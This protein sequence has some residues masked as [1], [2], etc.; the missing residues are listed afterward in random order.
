MGVYSVYARQSL[1]AYDRKPGTLSLGIKSSCEALSR[2]AFESSVNVLYILNN[3]NRMERIFQYFSTYTSE[4]RKQNQKW[5]KSIANLDP[6]D[7][8]PQRRGMAQ[9]TEFLNLAENFLGEIANQENVSYPPQ[10][11]SI[12]TFDKFQD[13]S[14]E[15]DYRTLYAA[16]S[17]QIHNDAEDLL[18]NF[19]LSA[20]NYGNDEQNFDKNLI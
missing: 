8:I 2:V 1:Q 9:K 5:E 14:R 19:L 11:T 12:N 7:Q 17:S 10:K 16:M 4:E 6:Q 20:Y 18:N 13:L 15:I 3:P